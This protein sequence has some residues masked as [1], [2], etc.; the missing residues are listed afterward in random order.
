[1]AYK[2]DEKLGETDITLPF[3]DELQSTTEDARNSLSKLHNL[4]LMIAESQP[5]ITP[6]VLRFLTQSIEYT[7]SRLPAWERSIEEVKLE[8]ELS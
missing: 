6:D 2:L 1:M 7:A 4:Q 5:L 3:F 8:F